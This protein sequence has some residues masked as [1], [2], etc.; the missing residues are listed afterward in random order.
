M[1]V[2]QQGVIAVTWQSRVVVFQ[3]QDIEASMRHGQGQICVGNDIAGRKIR[4]IMACLRCEKLA[5]AKVKGR[6]EAYLIRFSSV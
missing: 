3:W 6:A 4:Q 1:M 2:R 5:T